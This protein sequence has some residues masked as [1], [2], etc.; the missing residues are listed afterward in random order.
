MNLFQHNSIQGCLRVPAGSV[1]G[2]PERE[3]IARVS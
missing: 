2:K 3:Y 1:W